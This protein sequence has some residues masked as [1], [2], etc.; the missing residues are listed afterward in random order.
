MKFQE[1]SMVARPLSVV[2]FGLSLF[3]VTGCVTSKPEPE[4]VVLRPEPAY[5]GLER[6]PPPGVDKM[7]WIEPQVNY[8]A[9]GPGV[10][11]EGKWYHPSYNAVRQVKGGRWVKCSELSK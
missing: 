7:C 8:E 10:D 2:I 6:E 11:A 1:Y 4:V 5:V 3:C 9:N